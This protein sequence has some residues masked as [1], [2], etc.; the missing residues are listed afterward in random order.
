M[1]RSMGELRRLN[2]EW[3][4]LVDEALGRGVRYVVLEELHRRIRVTPRRHFQMSR[5]EARD[6]VRSLRNSIAPFFEASV[7]GVVDPLLGDTFGVEIEMKMP[8]GMSAETVANRLR[9]KGVLCYVENYNHNTRTHWKITTDGSLG[10]GQGREVVSPPLQGEAGLQ[11]VRKVTQALTELGCRVDRQCGLHVHIGAQTH[12]EINW[13]KNIVRMSHH[14]EMAIDSFMSP[15]RRGMA[16]HWCRPLNVNWS[17]F[18]DASNLSQL[19]DACGQPQRYGARSEYRYRKLNLLSFLQCGTIEFRQHQGTVE[20]QK[21]EMWIRFLLRLTTKAVAV[22]QAEID[23]AP[24][25]LEG[26]MDFL[27]CDAAE[28]AY[29]TERHQY[30]ARNAT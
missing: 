26:L 30:F 16:S 29:F 15:S 3:N 13:W 5:V 12:Q 23:N 18:D 10:Y 27:G 9:E 19:S 28:R 2:I 1:P 6:R 8:R 22:V 14:F 7:T 20:T 17:R 25:S 11:A 21:T 4:Q 24:K